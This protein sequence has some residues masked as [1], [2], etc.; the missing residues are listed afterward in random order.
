MSE[1]EYLRH[2]GTLVSEG[3]Y[4]RHKGTLVPLICLHHTTVLHFLQ[5]CLSQNFVDS[6][7]VLRIYNFFI[8]LHNWNRQYL[9]ISSPLVFC[10]RLCYGKSSNLE[11]LCSTASE[12]VLS[13]TRYAILKA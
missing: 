2:K 8:T 13:D 3:E 6:V 11:N 12:S 9:Y 7:S 4:L 10:A 1:G 5:C